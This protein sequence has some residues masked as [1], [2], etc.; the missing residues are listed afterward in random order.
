MHHFYDQELED[1]RRKLVLMGEK[2]MDIT[3][4]AI[5]ALEE[6]NLELV[7]RVLGMDDELDE[8]EL[9][10]DGDAVRY[11]SLRAPVATDVRLLALCMKSCHDLERVGDEACSVAKRVRRLARRKSPI[12]DLGGLPA[13]TEA[14]VKQL[15]AALDCFIDEHYD[16]AMALPSSDRA[17]DDMNRTNFDRFMERATAEPASVPIAI[18]LIFISKSLER[19]GDHA[20]NLA[21]EVAYLVKAKDVRHSDAVRRAPRQG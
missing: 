21:E 9:Q 10:I 3:R 1:I 11:L 19:I 18:E 17:I 12:G 2:A 15:R 8:L 13:M 7:Q 14:V 20:V 6:S 4:L 5:R 16:H